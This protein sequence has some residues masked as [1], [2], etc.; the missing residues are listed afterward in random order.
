MFYN[1]ISIHEINDTLEIQKDFIDWYWWPFF[2][3]TSLAKHYDILYASYH[4]GLCFHKDQCNVI[5][6]FLDSNK[7]IA[8]NL[9]N[10]HCGVEEFAIHESNKEFIYIGNGWKE[11][12]H[13]ENKFYSIRSKLS[14]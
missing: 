8:H 10:A 1:K 7:E 12:I 6:S 5:L 4:E 11:G 14:R 2:K 9:F 3:E 13:K